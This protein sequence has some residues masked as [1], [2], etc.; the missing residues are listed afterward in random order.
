VFL[1]W[2]IE[3]TSFKKYPIILRCVKVLL[4]FVIFVAT[5][6]TKARASEGASQV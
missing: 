4:Y 5:F 1:Q 3:R 2:N 6:A